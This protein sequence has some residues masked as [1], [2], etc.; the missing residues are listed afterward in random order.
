MPISIENKKINKMLRDVFKD[1]PK[2]ARYAD[3]KEK[4]IINVLSCSNSPWEG[5]TSF[6]TL[7]L[8][9]HSTGKQVDGIPLGVELVGACYS[10]FDFFPNILATCSFNIIN[11]SF[12]C[13]PG[14]IYLNVVE[15]YVESPVKHIL[16]L[17]PSIWDKKFETLY[18][19]PQKIVAWL[20]IVPIS[21]KELDYSKANGTEALENLFA[22]EQMDIFDLSRKSVL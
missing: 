21:D 10:E 2:Y 9:D 3:E 22:R 5:V 18:F 7:G 12:K 8:S 11:S 20:Q 1:N 14:S 13:E 4:S 15:M 17:A 16:F 19:Q 6:G